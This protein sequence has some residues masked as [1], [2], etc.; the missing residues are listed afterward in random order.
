MLP[1]PRPKAPTPGT[2]LP[3]PDKLSLREKLCYG[4]GDLGSCLYWQTFTLYLTFF[5][6]DVFGIGAAAAGTMIAVARI[7]DGFV[8]IGMGMI[9]DRTQTRW[10]KFRP[11][12]LWFCLPLAAMGVL[13]FTVPSLGASGKLVWAY[14]TY[15]LLMFL[16][17]S[18][19]IPY[20]VL[21]GVL[22]S[23]PVERTTLS[24]IKLVGA[25]AGGVIIS[26]TLLPMA[27]V[28]GWL[29]ARTVERGWQLS[30]VIIGLAAIACYLT[31]FFNSRERIAPPRAQKTS[32]LR[33]LRDAAMN[34]PWLILMGLT[35]T[36]A[37]V[38]ALR[39]SVT[40]YYFK[41]YVGAQAATLPRILF[42]PAGG[43]QV[44]SWES[45]A[46]AFN[47]STQVAAIVGVVLAP[48]FVRLAGRKAAFVSMY[49]VFIATT[50]LFYVIRPGQLGL[51]FGL[52]LLG[53]V[54]GGPIAA[55][56]WAM[57]ADS[58]DY[59][60]WKYGR[61]ATGLAFSANVFCDK[62]VW[63]IGSWMALTMM[64]SVGFVPNTVQTASS[65][66]GLI[67]LMSVLPAAFGIPSI[68]LLLFYPLNERRM[69]QV[70]ADLARRRAADA[71]P[72][73][74]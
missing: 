56:L 22:S 29:G 60:E 32:V 61:R 24:S 39:G 3:P 69:A 21:L 13:T 65:I 42:G 51:I 57:F 30:F 10:G 38:S 54:T 33:D 70:G 26:A 7:L 45:L 6:T 46:S 8:D 5:Y 2:P 27:K 62:Q 28:G 49:L 67:L 64:A 25:Y 72:A 20:T 58:A 19:D 40:A 47:T 44:W 37:F 11:F 74:A 16:Y 17:S 66:H 71:A 53:S 41:Y 23:D 59:G 12:L 73:G 52:N 31:T 15:N 50:A 43:T 14:T 1:S 36:L 4:F 48:A 34:G 35:I 55:V 68:I 63:G 18:M 9:A